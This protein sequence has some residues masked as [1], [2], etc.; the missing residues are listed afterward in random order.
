MSI[1]PNADFWLDSPGLILI[2]LG[3]VLMVIAFAWIWCLHET[4]RK[5]SWVRQFG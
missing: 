4:A 2:K 1:Y 5:W 3:V